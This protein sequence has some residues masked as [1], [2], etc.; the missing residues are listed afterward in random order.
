M[1]Y[2]KQEGL[3]LATTRHFVSVWSSLSAV[4]IE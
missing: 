4:I 3:G 2:S 1:V